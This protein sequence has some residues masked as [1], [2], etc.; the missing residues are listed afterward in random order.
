MS[1]I[2]SADMNSG[3]WQ[4][5]LTVWLVLLLS[6]AAHSAGECDEFVAWVYPAKQAYILEHQLYPVPAE[7]QALAKRF[8][9]RIWVSPESWQPIS[10]ETYLASAKLKR[11]SDDKILQ[12][13]PTVQH[14]QELNHAQQCSTYLQAGEVPPASPA[15]LYVQVFRDRSPIDAAEEWLYIKY[16]P[17]FS[18]SG[19]AKEIS[20]AASLGVTLTG[21]DAGRWHRLDV[22]TSAILAF[23]SKHQFKMLTLAQH[24]HQQTFLTGRDLPKDS[25]PLLVAAVQSNELYLDDGNTIPR[26]HRVVP[27]FNKVSY[28]IDSQEK[29]WLWATD[30]SYGRNSGGVEIEFFP[31]YHEPNHPL[32]DYAGLLAPPHRIMGIYIGRDGPPGMNYYAPP[33]YISIPDFVTMGFWQQGNTTLLNKLLPHLGSLEKTNWLRMLEIFRLHLKNANIQ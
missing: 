10:F 14:L 19:L 2:R 13:S 11:F 23:N 25:P 9:P 21:G 27:F 30:L 4:K 1:S 8:M 3:F 5:L 7:I 12:I 18:W 33:S 15:P 20:W 6:T 24:N 32:V 17:V 28:L 22:H 26:K 31:I 29:P 16:N